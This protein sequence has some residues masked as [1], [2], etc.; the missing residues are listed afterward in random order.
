MIKQTIKPIL[1]TL[2]FYATGRLAYEYF[3]RLTISLVESW[4]TVPL[5]FFGKFPFLFFGDPTF[6]LILASIPLTVFMVSKLLSD[7]RKILPV[8]SV[9]YASYFL[10]TYLVACWVTSFTLLASNDLYKNGQ[11]LSYH[12]SE[13]N[14]NQI[15][16]TSVI[17]S[18][19]LTSATLITIKSIAKFKSNKIGKRR[20]ESDVKLNAS[21]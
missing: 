20:T 21:N 4:S 3:Y 7:R 13:V 5:K 8:T 9:I 2:I 14:L 18:T 19:I 17:G 12:L 15:Y 1:V 11:E 16:L 6:G 10:T